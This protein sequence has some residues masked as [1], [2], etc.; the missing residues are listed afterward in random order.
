[1]GPSD[2]GHGSLVPVAERLFGGAL[3]QAGDNFPGDVGAHL[4]RRWGNPG[5][6]LFFFPWHAS[7]IADGK[8]IWV[9]RET[10]VG[11]DFDPTLRV[12]GNPELG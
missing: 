10:E 1:M 8:N 12:G 5:D 2:G 4:H 11:P 6:Q 3:F 9:A 7:V